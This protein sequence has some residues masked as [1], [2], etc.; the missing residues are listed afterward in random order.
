MQRTK[1]FVAHLLSGEIRQYHLSLTQEL[2][3]RFNVAPLHKRVDPHITIKNFEANEFELAQVEHVLARITADTDPIP[4]TIE[5]F[6]KFGYKTFFLDVQK[7]RDALMFARHCVY[8]LN[9]LRWISVGR[10][11]G[12]KLHASVARYL[13]ARQ[14]RRIWRL[15][16][17]KETPHFK[18]RLDS[19]TIFKKPGTRWEAHRT[20][21]LHTAP[22]QFSQDLLQLPY[23]KLYSKS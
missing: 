21:H 19:I 2:A 14:S 6:G 17:R 22:V 3:T 23:E 4:L 15:L 10:H 1:Y 13:R 11:E 5:G 9:R 20:F 7:S 12:E 16:K 8:E 18:T